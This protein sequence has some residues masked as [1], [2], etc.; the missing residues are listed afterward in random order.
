MQHLVLSPQ[1]AVFLCPALPTSD[2]VVSSIF[3]ASPKHHQSPNPRC[4]HVW[5][6]ISS[7]ALRMGRNA[8]TSSLPTPF[9]ARASIDF[10]CCPPSATAASRRTVGPGSTLFPELPSAAAKSKSAPPASP[11]TETGALEDVHAAGM[12]AT[13]TRASVKHRH[14]SFSSCPSSTAAH[15]SSP[16]FDF[17]YVGDGSPPK[18]L[19]ETSV[20]TSATDSDKLQ[21][22]GP[23]TLF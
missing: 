9:R 21:A 6:S 3:P 4:R 15:L 13:G 1:S 17:F 5:R 18:I 16:S 2:Y 19:S 23:S 7:S 14:T 8:A 12:R 11:S 10:Q 20:F 22:V